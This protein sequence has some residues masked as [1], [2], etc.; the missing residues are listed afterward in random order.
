MN[1]MTARN[2]VALSDLASR[3]RATHAAVTEA[4]RT[5]TRH[6]IECGGLLIEAK[7]GVPHGAWLPW[8]EEHC[9]LSDRTAQAYM[10]LARRLPDLEDPKAQRVADLPVRQAMTAIADHRGETT[11]EPGTWEWAEQQTN[12]PFNRF[13]FDGSHELR[14]GKLFDQLS[15]PMVTAFCLSCMRNGIPLLRLA[16]WDEMYTAIERLLP[17]AEGDISALDIDWDDLARPRLD[18]RNEHRFAGRRNRP[19][20]YRA[21]GIASLLEIEAAA[22]VGALIIEIEYREKAYKDLSDDEYT[23]RYKIEFE[24]TRQAFLSDIRR[25]REE[26][27]AGA[28]P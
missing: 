3:I 21:A 26:L 23:E 8:L 13:D 10:R 2:E 28:A 9:Q 4:A 1:Q 19:W 15:I 5:A 14:A 17:I 27:H 16:P 24:E 20:A 12:G 22:Y 25:Q 11:A 18:R 7:S 6:A